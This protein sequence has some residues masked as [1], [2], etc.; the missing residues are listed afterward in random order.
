LV[1][2]PGWELAKKSAETQ[3]SL[4]EMPIIDAFRVNTNVLEIN[5]ERHLKITNT[6]LR[7]PVARL[8]SRLRVNRA[9]GEAACL[10]VSEGLRA[11]VSGFLQGIWNSEQAFNLLQVAEGGLNEMNR[12]LVKRR[13]IAAQS[14]N[15]MMNNNNRESLNAEFT[16]LT[17]E[18]DRI[19]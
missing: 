11:E 19:A 4:K 12:L 2:V 16:Q 18:V 7:K 9:A 14:A 6:D 17:N 8:S 5:A 1:L 15:S 13:E 10:S 3:D